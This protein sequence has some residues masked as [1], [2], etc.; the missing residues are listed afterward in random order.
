MQ[1]INKKRIGAAQKKASALPGLLQLGIFCFVFMFFSGTEAFAFGKRQ[2]SG[3]TEAAEETTVVDADAD[4]PPPTPFDSIAALITEGNVEDAKTAFVAANDPGDVDSLGRNAVHFAA[5]AR[6]SELADFFIRLGTPADAGDNGGYTPLNISA[7]LLDGVTAQILVRNGA[8]IHNAPA[9]V[10]SPA[11]AAIDSKDDAFLRAL[12]TPETM[13]ST[14][15]EGRTV[16]HLAV[17][18]G[19]YAAVTS[20]MSSGDEITRLELINKRD[21][22]NRTALD[23]AF[24]H[25]DSRSHAT[26]AEILIQ[27]G[28]F[29]SDP[30]F[31]Y[32]APVVRSLNFNQRA[33]DGNSAL[34]YSTRER[35]RGFTLYLL[36]HMADPNIKNT[37]GDTALHEAARIGDVEIME[38]LLDHGANV[39]IQDG[40]GNTAMHIAIPVEVHR[41]ALELLFSY[42][43]NPNLRDERGDS[44]AHIVISLN[45][46]P[47][48]LETLLKNGADLTIHNTDG[49]TPLFLA[50]E[51]KRAALLPL[52]V[53][54]RSD[55]FAMTNEGKTPFGLALDS[56]EEILNQLIT[57]ETVLQSDNN[58]NTPLLVAVRS[59]ADVK[60]VQRILD[61]DALINARNLEGDTALHIAVRQDSET[62]GE[63][64]IARGA[65][66]FAQNAKGE[67]PIYL[68]FYSPGDVREWM[69]TPAVLTA[70]DGLGNTL[71]H[72]A[73]Q[74][75]LDSA[76]PMIASRGASLEAANVTGETPLFIA[77]KIDSSSTVQ[78]LLGAGASIAGRD[79]LG[80]TAL[81]TAVRWNALSAA[82]TLV[83]A[84]IDINAYNL[85]GKTPL[86][87]SVRLGV[88]GMESLL[89][90]RGAYLEARDKDGNTPLVEAVMKGSFRSTEHLVNSGANVST[91]NNSGD[92]PLLIAVEGERSDLVGILL[93]KRAQIHAKDAD[94]ESPFTV[95][96]KTSPR[97]MLTL[98]DKGRD[99]TDDAGRTPLHIALS[100]NM[101]ETDIETIAN[102]LGN[103]SAVDSEGR[104][105]LRYAVDRANWDAAKFLADGGADIFSIA[106]DG[107]TPAEI[108]LAAENRDAV[109]AV[110][111]GKAVTSRDSEGNSILHYAARTAT[112][113]TVSLLIELGADKAVRNT[114]GDSPYDIARRWNRQDIMAILR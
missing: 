37:T 65:D 78:A 26:V 108:T 31:L 35:Y 54:Y 42:R 85:Y 22:T 72:Y 95:A 55:I 49:K 57:G 40:Q 86:H 62:V 61:K 27:A 68:T 25:R 44:P 46:T 113:S 63:L 106:R 93:D 75:R 20:I 3:K 7:G 45:R 36:D 51:Q 8:F 87:D 64:L 99:Q 1:S 107:K 18:A 12:L 58:G 47:D 94:G 23:Y 67:S 91:R 70:R 39:N 112:A 60:L 76:I 89:V 2:S 98:L 74:W 101:P 114:A 41:P 19:S 21:K 103:T 6:N 105:A 109:R 79:T 17:E 59:G 10:A 96:L 110:F 104:T 34:H 52:L 16:L 50:V 4:K 11:V 97:M 56:E 90:E 32:F 82:D 38:A 69:L 102:W 43:A 83:S 48:I 14:D 33:A 84:K 92:T 77:V 88:F 73:T 5:A 24:I 81:H 66:V 29:S 53:S 9:G 100:Y 71:L 30:F 111:G 80:N 15:G 28:G 13:L